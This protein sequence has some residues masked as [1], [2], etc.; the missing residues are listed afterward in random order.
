MK[1][2][3]KKNIS[4]VSNLCNIPAEVIFHYIQEEWVFPADK[5][6]LML[7][8]EDVARIDLINQLKEDFGVNDESVPVIL[9]LVDYL[10]VLMRN[11][12]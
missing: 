3:F 6:S 9:H 11:L 1:K 7:D 4:D 8:E 12:K 2:T 10:N 5:Q